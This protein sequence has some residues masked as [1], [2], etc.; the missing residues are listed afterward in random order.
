MI[1]KKKNA[2]DSFILEPGKVTHTYNP[3]YSG[4]RHQEDGGWRPSLAKVS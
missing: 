2:I 1:T 4:G 3:N